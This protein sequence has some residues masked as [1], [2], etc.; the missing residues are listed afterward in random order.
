M[1]VNSLA[2]LSNAYNLHIGA[3]AALKPLIEMGERAAAYFAKRVGP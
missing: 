2:E 1:A 3:S